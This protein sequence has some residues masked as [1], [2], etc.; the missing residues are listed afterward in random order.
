MTDIEI[1]KKFKM[2]N[3][4][5]LLNELNDCQINDFKIQKYDLDKLQTI[6]NKYHLKQL[7]EYLNKNKQINLF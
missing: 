1:T 6:I 7:D 2:K 4:E 3:I 5:I